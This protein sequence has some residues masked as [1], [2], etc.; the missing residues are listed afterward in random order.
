MDQRSVESL[1]V[2]PKVSLRCGGQLLVL[3]GSRTC[4]VAMGWGGA[5]QLAMAGGAAGRN[6]GA[7][8]VA[9][10][11]FTIRLAGETGCSPGRNAVAI[12]PAFHHSAA[13]QLCD[14]ALIRL[15]QLCW[16]FSDS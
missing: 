10:R 11:G 14:T 6:L 15:E 7:C 9:A 8:W 5:R 16:L 13:C 2:T 12:K 3:V 1:F 4:N